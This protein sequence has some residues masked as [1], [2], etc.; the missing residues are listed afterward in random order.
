MSE[1]K[2]PKKDLRARLG[3]TIAPNTPGAP[4]IA[5]PAITPPAAASGGAAPSPDAPAITPPVVAPPVIAPPVVAGPKL[6]FG[7]DIAPPPF[8]KPAAP[9]EPPK[10]EPRK[11]SADPFAAAAPAADQVRLIIEEKADDGTRARAQGRTNMIVGGI[12]IAVGIVGGMF[13]GG[14]NGAHGL[15]NITVR[16]AHDVHDTFEAATQRVTEASQHLD[17]IATA[18]NP[19]TAGAHP[20]LNYDELAALTAL[21]N[22][23][24]AGAF[25]RKNFQRIPAATVDD[26]FVYDHNVQALWEQFGRLNALT[27]G[28]ARRAALDATAAATA[29]PGDLGHD[30]GSATAAITAADSASS[31]A[32]HSQ[33]VAL[34]Q[35]ADDG[36]VTGTL[37]FAE[38]DLT[39][40]NRV[41]MRAGRTGPGRAFDRWTPASAI[42]GT[43]Q[44]VLPID[45]SAS[46]GVLGDRTGAFRAFADQLHETRALMR[47]T[48]EIQQ[49]L[50]TALGEVQNIQ[51][52]FAF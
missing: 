33:Y 42:T 12:A 24:H 50:T 52:Q 45:G 40:P 37:G 25:S 18:A 51:E 20:T 23:L 39:D 5:A 47:E 14:A 16:D 10:P 41:F 11:R 49:R 13:I 17:A 36:S 4:P 48:I 3:R 28:P 31:D 7:N 2:K 21:E 8:A 19:T 32:A 46:A 15:Y 34:L 43:P 22:P 44:F 35:T 6:P 1:D 30:E 26:L 27:S 29:C 38:T 9:A